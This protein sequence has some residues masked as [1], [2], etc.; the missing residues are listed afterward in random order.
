MV[1]WCPWCPALAT[2]NKGEHVFD[3]W[4]NR[5]HGREIKDRYRFTQ[6]GEDGTVLRAY[7]RRRID[8]TVPSVCDECNSGWM[9]KLTSQTKAVAEGMIRWQRPTTLLPLGIKTL[10]AFVFMKVVVVDAEHDTR[11]FSR[12]TC[13]R[14][15][16]TRD[17]PPGLQIWV[18]WF[19]STQ[20]M[21]AKMWSNNLIFRSSRFRGY[22]IHVFTY[23]VGH[24][25]FQLTFP[26]WSTKSLRPRAPL[27]VLTQ[28]GHWDEASI[29]IWPNVATITWPPDKYLDADGLNNFKNRFAN[30]QTRDV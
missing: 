8:T 12:A 27:P 21:A 5:L 7:I 17:L 4:L 13:F 3:D 26:R 6:T 28:A 18:A 20:R 22:N 30:L 1:K 2:T 25:A 16:D 14:F 11:N 23:V 29:P 24:L 10:A 15:A 19:R 9:S